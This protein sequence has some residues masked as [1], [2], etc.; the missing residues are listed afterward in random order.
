MTKMAMRIMS[1]MGRITE[2]TTMEAVDRSVSE[3][4]TE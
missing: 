4:K 1:W 2:T 3:P